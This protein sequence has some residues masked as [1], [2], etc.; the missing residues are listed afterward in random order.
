MEGVRIL[1]TAANT[2]QNI[3][4]K[5]PLFLDAIKFHESIFALPFAYIGMFLAADGFP[6]WH[7]FIW[8]TVAMVSARTVG[9]AANRIIDRHIDAKNPRAAVRH[10]PSGLL[11]VGEM[12]GLT[13]IAL[14][15]FIIAAAQLNT[16]ALIL[17][18]V[19]AAYLILYPFT[20]RFTWAAN[21]LLGWALAIS[22]SAAWIGVTGSLP[23]QPVMLSLAVALWA[24]SFDILYHTQDEGFHL[25]E[26]LH[27]VASRFGIVNAFRIARTLDTL[28]V[29][30]L[31]VLGIWM[32][33]NWPYFVGCVGAVGF[34]LY[35]YSLVNPGDLSRM[36]L[37]FARINAYISTT[38][39]VG[40]LIAIYL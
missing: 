2:N 36:G 34:L 33:L 14:V 35:K 15:V 8:I 22:P 5:V 13:V 20:K 38:M 30:V 37:A 3:I 25:K 9:M 26:G 7:A 16:L 12:V 10:L 19:A 17:A 27:S 32:G 28:A 23:L 31:V 29:T 18:P 1:T 21:L 24:G 40:T 6:G 4:R 39:L 11:K